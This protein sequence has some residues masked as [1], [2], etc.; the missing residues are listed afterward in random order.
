VTLG[1]VVLLAINIVM[2]AACYAL[3]RSGWKIKA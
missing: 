1:A 3:L 2:G